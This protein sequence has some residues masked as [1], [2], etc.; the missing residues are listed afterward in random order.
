M[1]IRL[2]ESVLAPIDDIQR[3]ASQAFNLFNQSSVLCLPSSVLCFFP[4]QLRHL[5]KNI[6]LEFNEPDSTAAGQGFVEVCLSNS[7]VV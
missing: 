5:Q 3:L 4:L 1:N 2:L 7:E 6:G